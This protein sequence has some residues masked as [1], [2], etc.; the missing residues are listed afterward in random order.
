MY[1]VLLDVC[2]LH[3]LLRA[4]T[5]QIGS[6]SA[7]IRDVRGQA[8][9]QT[10]TPILIMSQAVCTACFFQHLSYYQLHVCKYARLCYGCHVLM[11]LVFVTT[12]IS[13]LKVYLSNAAWLDMAAGF[14]QQEDAYLEDSDDE[15]DDKVAEDKPDADLSSSDDRAEAAAA[16]VSGQGADDSHV[17]AAGAGQVS[18]DQVSQPVQQDTMQAEQASSL[19]DFDDGGDG[20]SGSGSITLIVRKGQQLQE[21]LVD[22]VISRDQLKRE[23]EQIV[24]YMISS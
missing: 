7:S 18:D 2:C 9:R 20:A 14:A 16:S 10:G 19:Q 13:A 4:C 24:S 11:D 22:G 12:L 17:A 21:L 1:C 23:V 8:G 5:S 15:V 6:Q 3:A